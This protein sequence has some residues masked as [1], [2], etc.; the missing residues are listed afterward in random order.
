MSDGILSQ[1]EIDAL[2]KG[3]DDI[4]T[5]FVPEDVTGDELSEIE[6]DA[7]GE[8]S[9]ITLGTASTTLSTLLGKKVSITVPSVTV[10]SVK[11]FEMEYGYP[12]TV[13]DVKYTEG[14][15]GSNVLILKN[16]DAAII[17]DLMMGGEGKVE[18]AELNELHLSAVSEAMNQMMGSSAT[19]MSTLI[20]KT[21]NIAP[22]QVEIVN[23]A[24]DGIKFL[25]PALNKIA[26][27]KFNMQIEGLIDSKLVQ[28][29]TLDFAKEMAISLIGNIGSS[30]SSAP[31]QASKPQQ[32]SYSYNEQQV[33][34]PASPQTGYQNV[35]REEQRRPQENVNVSPA[36]FQQLDY[37]MNIT[38][39][40][41]LDLILDVALNVSVELGRTQKTVKEILDFSTGSIIELNK[42]AGE[43][44]DLMINGKL[45]AKGEVV[46]IDENFG[47]RI[48]DIVSPIER[49]KKLQ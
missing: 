14:L 19:S 40:Q 11:D 3:T 10:I 38:G 2:L 46:V 1:A 22:P 5:D 49:V 34:A 26:L 7:V 4:D 29:I 30:P 45:F 48:L 24:E 6:R 25:D 21:I 44:V 27:V 18:V 28:I 39:S 17:A 42:L 31:A 12:H 33:A 35:A 32:D 13:V 23:I 47:V 9:N 20:N 43:A 15:V 41:N 16:M 8:V 36:E 37:N